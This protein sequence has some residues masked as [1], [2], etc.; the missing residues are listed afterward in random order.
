MPK[1]FRRVPALTNTFSGVA[2][3]ARVAAELLRAVLKAAKPYWTDDE[4]DRRL[5]ISCSKLETYCITAVAASGPIANG[6]L[7]RG[8]WSHT[9]NWRGVRCRLNPQMPLVTLPLE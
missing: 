2:G 5:R 6:V 7:R 8:Y 9:N 3:E 4:A 1:P